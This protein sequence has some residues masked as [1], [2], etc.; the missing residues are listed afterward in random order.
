MAEPNYMKDH[1]CV[2]S[3]GGSS[4]EP[5][6]PSPLCNRVFSGRHASHREHVEIKHEP[7]HKPAPA[8]TT[9]V[10]HGDAVPSCKF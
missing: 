8:P 10:V 9:K 1:T 3:H 5:V 4:G 6:K 2:I 7:F